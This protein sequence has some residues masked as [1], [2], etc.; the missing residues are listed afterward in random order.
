MNIIGYNELSIQ[1]VVTI[2][3]KKTFDA[4][5]YFTEVFRHSDFKSEALPEEIREFNLCQINESFSF[6][7]TFR[8][9]H[10]QLNPPQAKCVRCIEGH[11]IDLALD[12]RPK[13]KT[14]GKILAY[15]II[16]KIE[17]EF[18]E[19]LWVPAGIAHGTL[20]LEDSRLEYL[21]S[22]EWNSDS[23][24][25]ISIFSDDIDWAL[26]DNETQIRIQS[27]IKSNDLKISQKDK[28]AQVFRSRNK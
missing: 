23:S 3:C 12:L 16:S 9:L 7:N 19:W 17:E 14:Y 27:I 8:G 25:E 26:C 21:C 5:G 2:K 13:S 28:S 15:E 24:E 11:L 4:R 1:G 20:L 6:K 22:A 10:Y 18:F